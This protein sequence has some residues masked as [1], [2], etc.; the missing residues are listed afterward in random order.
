MMIKNRVAILV[1]LVVLAAA[2][3]LAFAGDRVQVGAYYFPDYHP[4]EPLNDRDHAPGWDEWSLVRSARPL[5]PGEQQPK[6]PRWGYEDESDPKVMT[7]KIDAASK[8]GIDAFIFDWYWYGGKPFL[9]KCLDDGFLKSPNRAKIKFALM[10]ANHDWTDIFPVVKDRPQKLMY[11][12]QVTREQFDA[13]CDHVI[14]DY[15]RQPNYWRIDGKPYFSI[16]QVDK[17]IESFGGVEQT[18]AA[19]DRFRAKAVEAGLPGIHINA[20][21]QG[22]KTPRG[23]RP[24]T[25][26]ALAK[27]LRVDS[28]GSYVWIHHA[29][30]E[31]E[32]T[33]YDHVRDGYFRYWTEAERR[34]DVPYFPNVTM[35]WDPTPRNYLPTRTIIGNT[36][37]KFEQALRMTRDRVEKSKLS[38]KVIT[39]N[40]WNEWTEGSYLEPDTVHGMGYLDAMERVFGTEH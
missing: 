23:M 21:T 32:Q 18:R 2:V 5:Y 16:Y 19:L 34:F 3:S 10:W 7:R 4:G 28:V 6:V 15:F 20:I 11:R 37:A 22:L 1:A 27:R 26:E 25:A 13:M 17:L 40:S 8:A 38:P 33:D 9:E 30:P 24:S 36:P 35:G 31:K 12:G 39:I 14:R 29:F